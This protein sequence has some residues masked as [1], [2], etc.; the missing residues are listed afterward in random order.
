MPLNLD[1]L[2]QIKLLGDLHESGVLNDVKFTNE[3]YQ[4][5]G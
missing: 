2:V 4:I 5:L 3:K 1:V